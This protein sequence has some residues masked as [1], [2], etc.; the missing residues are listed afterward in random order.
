[1]VK[2]FEKTFKRKP[3]ST[4]FTPYRINPIGAHSDYG[5]GKIIGFTLDKGIHMAYAAMQIGLVEV[6]SH[7]SPKRAQIKVRQKI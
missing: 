7:R 2:E 3:D 1:M 4:A 5:L 6:F